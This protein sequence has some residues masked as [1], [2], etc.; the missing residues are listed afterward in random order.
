MFSSNATSL[1]QPP[2][3]VTQRHSPELSPHRPSPKLQPPPTSLN[4][5]ELTSASTSASPPRSRGPK[6]PQGTPPAS[7]MSISPVNLSPAS[8][9][10]T[11]PTLPHLLRNHATSPGPADA[12]MPLSAYGASSSDIA[13]QG[14]TPLGL[15]SGF[16][17]SFTPVCDKVSYLQILRCQGTSYTVDLF[18]PRL[19]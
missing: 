16:V 11:S 3:D 10:H 17:P 4:R 19:M 5:L 6:T 14:I 18:F 2:I 7:P 15:P 9:S 8:L 12:V 13:C 1:Q